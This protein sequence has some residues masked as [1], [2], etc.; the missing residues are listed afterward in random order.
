MAKQ[1]GP[2]N[3]NTPPNRPNSQP[4]RGNPGKGGNNIPSHRNPPPPPP[5]RPKQ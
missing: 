2:R 1:E 3:P 4:D 5:P